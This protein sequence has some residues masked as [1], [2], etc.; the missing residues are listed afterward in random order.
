MVARALGEG[1]ELPYD[2]DIPMSIEEG[3][4]AL[5]CPVNE[6]GQQFGVRLPTRHQAAARR[7][8]R[9]S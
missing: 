2:C 7:R 8:G 3:N 1:R 5:I 9:G 4:D 6:Q